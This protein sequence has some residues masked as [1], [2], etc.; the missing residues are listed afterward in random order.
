[1]NKGKTYLTPHQNRHYN[2]TPTL[3][4][5]GNMAREVQHVSNDN[6]LALFGGSSAYP[7]SE[8]DELTGRFALEGS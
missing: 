6:C 2:L 8:V 7:A 4:I 3:R 1:M 5:T